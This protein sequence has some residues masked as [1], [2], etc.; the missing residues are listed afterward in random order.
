MCVCIEFILVCNEIGS[1][2]VFPA[3]A[4][5]RFKLSFTSVWKANWPSRP[6]ISFISFFLVLQKR[7]PHPRHHYRYMRWTTN[8]KTN[9]TVRLHGSWKS[10]CR[11]PSS[12]FSLSL[13]LSN[14]RSGA[15]FID[16]KINF[17]S[18]LPLPACW[19][20]KHTHIHMPPPLPPCPAN[21]HTADR[22]LINFFI[23]LL[24]FEVV[25]TNKI[26][27]RE[28]GKEEDKSDSMKS[29]LEFKRIGL[30][31]HTHLDRFGYVRGVDRHKPWNNLLLSNSC[32]CVCACK[33]PKNPFCLPKCNKWMQAR[34]DWYKKTFLRHRRRRGW[35][36][37]RKWT[38]RT[39][40]KVVVG[41]AVVCTWSSRPGKGVRFARNCH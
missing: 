10:I 24:F 28:T 41:Y 9:K 35:G 2:F 6:P 4:I 26:S 3:H 14:C 32:V 36:G 31:W 40:Q 30:W 23:H 12:L 29:R 34:V 5:A 22:F 19:V 21:E 15:S 16:R 18:S 13:S 39:D 7:G 20:A 38:K 11:L 27:R 8:I 1:Y 37:R 25:T 17:F 33:W